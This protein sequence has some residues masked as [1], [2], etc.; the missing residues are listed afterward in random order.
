MVCTLLPGH[1]VPVPP[2]PSGHPLGSPAAVLPVSVQRGLS[3]PQAQAGEGVV[4]GERH[5]AQAVDAVWLVVD[6]LPVGA[7][8][9]GA[10][11]VVPVQIVV[12]LPNDLLIHHG[13]ELAGKEGGPG[14]LLCSRDKKILV[15][16]GSGWRLGAQLCSQV[17]C[18]QIPALTLS[19]LSVLSFFLCKMETIIRVS[20]WSALI[21][22]KHLEE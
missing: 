15:S 14:C 1:P 11:R 13:F 20:G 5:I 17:A 2:Q 21:F 12:Q 10:C 22:E 6:V 4:Q 18:I 16:S 19:N 8:A 9:R 7:E 3:P